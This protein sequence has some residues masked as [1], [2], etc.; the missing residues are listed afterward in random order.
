MELIISTFQGIGSSLGAAY[1]VLTHIWFI[2]LPVALYILFK[3]LWMDHVQIKFASSIDYD[4]IELIPP[5]DIEKSPQLMESLYTGMAG[6]LTTYNVLEEFV[7]GKFTYHFSLELVSNGGAMHYYIHTPKNFRNLVEAHLYAQYP[8]I[9]IQEVPDY[10]SDVP[11]IV[12][13]KD[14]DLWGTDFELVGPEPVPIK[15]YRSF[16]EDVTGNMIDPLAGLIETMG[17]LGPNQYIWMQWIATPIHEGWK[18]E[19]L[20]Y[21]AEITGRKK[22]PSGSMARRIVEGVIEFAKNLMPALFQPPAWATHEEKSA[23]EQPLE[24]RLTPGERKALEAIESNIGKNMFQ[25]KAR[26][27]YLGKREHF[28]KS[29]VS[30]FIGGLKQFADQNLNSFKPHN[31]S[32]TYANFILRKQR[33]RYRQRKIFRRYKDRDSTG[34]TCTLSTEELATVFHMPDMA[35]ISPFIRR[36]QAKR[37]GAPSNLPM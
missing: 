17:K 9:E 32:K 2:V 10:V 25:T 29:A 6:V 22:K 8:D 28:T 20:D 33:L 12:P 35:I 23:D 24:F 18:K 31:P 26:M 19:G 11:P 27:L 15:T 36:V 37:G 21:I 1:Q 30:S 3:Y 5:Q 13:N 16:E 14:W 4:I 7:D 34:Q